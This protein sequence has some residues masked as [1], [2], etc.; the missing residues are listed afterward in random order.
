MSRTT[1]AVNARA[2][3]SG[4]SIAVLVALGAC[5]ALS[6]LAALVYQT[7]WTREF[8][9]VFGTSELAVATVLAA[10]M[11]GLA[12]GAAL[13]ERLLPRIGR[14]V[15]AYALLELGIAVS[16]VVLVPLLLRAGS[17]ALVA[18]YGSQPTPPSSEH[19][20][21][22]LYY[23]ACAFVVL[24][25]PATLMGATLPLLARHAV[26]RDSEIGRRIG[27]LYAANTA[28]AVGGALL[29][30]FWLLPAFGLRATIFAAA[31][32]NGLVF[33]LAAAIARR[34]PAA[35]GSPA[36][37]AARFAG[38]SRWILPLMFASGAITFLHEVL[39]TRMLGHVVG[40]SIH[41]F[42]VMVASFLTGIALGGF[43]GAWLATTRERAIL[44]FIACELGAALS[45]A[46]AFLALDRLVP[47]QA[48][49]A[50]NALF[51][52]MLLLPLT[53]FIGATWPL[54]VRILADGPRTAAAASARVYAWNT[55]G[56]IA[57][58]VSAG[59]V[60]IPALR[61]EG[62]I[63]A[64]VVASAAL[65]AIAA[66]L[67]ARR[68]R[69]LPWAASALVLVA[70]V[71]F[72]PATPARLLLASPLNVSP[73][74]EILFYDVGRS[75]DVIVLGQDG[76]LVLRTN[77]LP[78]AMMDTPAA[79]PRFSGEFWMSSL[80]VLAR[81]ATRRMLIVGYGG[82][83]V[84][85]GVPP[86]VR[87]IDVIELEPVVIDAN[88]ATRAL[89]RRDPLLDPRVSIVTN[90]ARGAL[91][92]TARRYDAIVSQPSHPW[93]VGASHLYTREFL[94]LAADHLAP[95]GVF[96]QW[97][98]VRF[99]DEAL[100]RSLTATL[101]DVFGE[102][103]LYRPDPTTLVFLASGVPLDPETAVARTGH[104]LDA[105]PAH[106]ARLGINCAED[107][108]AALAADAPGARRLAAD[109]PLITDDRNRMATSSV[110]ELGRG[111]DPATTGRVLA[112]YDPLLRADSVVHREL[113]GRLSMSYIARRLSVQASA[114]AS[115]RT[116]IA[117]LGRVLGPTTQGDYVRALAAILDSGNEMGLQWFRE[118]LA[119]HPADQELR[120][121]LV[122]PQLAALA[123]G[124]AS[125]EE[126][127]LARGLAGEPRLVLDALTHAARN[128]WEALSGLDAALAAIA[129]T[130]PW[131]IDALQLR[132]DWRT[133]VATAG[134]GR[135]YGEEAM[136]L[137]DRA[138]IVQPTAA[139]FGLRVRAA[140]GA[141][142]PAAVVE[143]VAGY[144]RAIYVTAAQ[145]RS[146][147]RRSRARATL[148]GLLGV[149]DETAR[150]AP[151]LGTRTAAVRGQLLD[152]I[153]RLAP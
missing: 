135:G 122:R 34:A 48:G 55:V 89:R 90:D 94:Q 81:P 25:I 53:A 110:L 60:V 77:G 73:D 124:V 109:A 69:W 104:P 84:V 120:Y 99:L 112:P 151:E 97:M 148:D 113:A 133:R 82:G 152:S 15:L 22:S 5:F 21:L 146:A 149:L 19:G 3:T 129:W 17:A 35:G 16:A 71:A 56:A 96:V 95:G 147:E 31:A 14:P 20:G 45:A 24:A 136:A 12:L 93:T 76:G 29:A 116:R 101:L 47:A 88:R 142:R 111:M 91:Q 102:V 103:R 80:A 66:W 23:L 28:G 2:G 131:A 67:L 58:A 138:L 42:G 153:S 54:A 36:P 128:E 8:A 79:A 50:G 107:L 75:A 86:S 33:L 18:L 68:P 119:R 38:A 144:A 118:S 43:A 41:A 61:Y 139:L 114:D 46:I 4:G 134:A 6:G 132:A 44:A 125:P 13:V 106:Y 143:S 37:Q 57:G 98:N 51:G 121:E 108:V 130:R 9:L 100:L 145:S 30:A 7:A 92:L 115:T 127:G 87:A 10:Y 83:V 1:D 63:H 62:T 65:A 26:H 52:F 141:D 40:S 39:W 123:R 49:L 137:L 64:A 126:T 74:G 85:E 11:G 72:R 117:A 70:A 105:A 78:E 27:L 32:L 59:F 150:A 140:L